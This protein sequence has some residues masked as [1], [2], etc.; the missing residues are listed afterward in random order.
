MEKLLL[1]VLVMETVGV[2]LGVPSTP[3]YRY[4][5]SRIYPAGRPEIVKVVGCA[6]AA[7]EYLCAMYTEVYT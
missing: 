6:G 4:A 1:E 3:K 5:S 2:V 7:G